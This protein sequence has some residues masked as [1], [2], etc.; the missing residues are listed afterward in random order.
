MGAKVLARRTRVAHWR[1]AT[2]SFAVVLSTNEA[3]PSAAFQRH[4][5]QSREEENELRNSFYYWLS[6]K[7]TVICVATSTGSPLMDVG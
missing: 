2:T 6:V 1:I 4:S 5:A 3:R 7:F